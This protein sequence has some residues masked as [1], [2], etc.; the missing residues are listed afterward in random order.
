MSAL[1]D[2]KFY[3][4][5]PHSCSY[6]EDKQAIT[7]FMDPDKD[8]DPALYRHLADIGFRRSGQ[9]VYRPHCQGCSACIPARVVVNSF[10]PRRK[11]RKLFKKNQ[12]LLITRSEASYDEETYQLYKKYIS[13]QHRD[14]DM[15]PPS[16]EQF[17]SFLVGCPE[18]CCYY[19]FWLDEKLVAVAVTDELSNGLS[20]IY[21]FYDPEV[22]KTRSLGSYC[23]LWQIEEAK[24]LGLKHLH[25]GYWIKDCKKMSYK[26]Q[27][28]P[29]EVY[30][31]NR[32]V[33]LK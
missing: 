21:T 33:T 23:I 29:L 13:V 14:G 26:I 25:L 10:E 1:K 9:H 24:K 6:L 32:W 30:V 16:M 22:S 17:Q 3:A 2:L 19:K 5:Q 27:Y 18:F 12:D 4:T 31:N 15:Y 11:H 7:L 28:R 8:L 20:A